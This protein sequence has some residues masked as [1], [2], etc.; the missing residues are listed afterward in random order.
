[1]VVHHALWLPRRPGGV[2]YRDHLLL[3][4]QDVL[5]RIRRP[6]RYVVL[7]RVTLL[8]RVVDAHDLDAL[9]YAL[10]EVFELVVHKDHPGLGVL[11][12]VLHLVLPQA[13]IY[14]DHDQTRGG[15]CEGPFEH[16]GD[17]RAEEGYPV[18][19]LESLVL[20]ARG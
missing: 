3:V 1:V 5:H 16:R 9:V 12:D 8:T 14:G 7:V 11:D 18:T 13:G 19:L 15:Y 20:E 6:L 10:Q 17:V 4:L 2:V